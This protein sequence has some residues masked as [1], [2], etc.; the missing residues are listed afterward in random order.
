MKHFS[1]FIALATIG[2]FLLLLALE[3]IISIPRLLITTTL[4]LSSDSD[5]VVRLAVN[6]GI[7]LFWTIALVGY[8]VYKKGLLPKSVKP[9]HGSKVAWGH[10]CLITG[11]VLMV[12]I[13]LVKDLAL[14]MI[15]PALGVLFFYGLGILLIELARDRAPKVINA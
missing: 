15:L 12:C 6:S 14:L 8:W 4:G 9:G 2:S 10:R 3:P 5:S 13:L 1:Y 11:H 7:A